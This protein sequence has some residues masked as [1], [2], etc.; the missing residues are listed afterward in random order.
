[1]GRFSGGRGLH[2]PAA[3]LLA[4]LAVATAAAAGG[5]EQRSRDRPPPAHTGAFGEPSCQACHDD[6]PSNSGAGKLSITGVPE[7]PVPGRTYEIILLLDDPGLRAAGFQLSARFGDGRQAGTL[8][9][10]PDARGRVDVTVHRETAYA[11]HLYDGTDVA[12]RGSTRWTVLWT[13]P[14]SSPGDIV[15][16]AAGV[17]ADNDLSSLGDL[18]YTATASAG[19]PAKR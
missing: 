18:V 6:A 5:A 2:A 17:A 12:E 1:M 9:A 19:P 16:S 14:D 13:A 10:G 3:C 11:H 4:G 15:F 8:A 7:V